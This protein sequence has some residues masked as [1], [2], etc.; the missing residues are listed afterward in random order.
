MSFFI[1]ENWVAEKKAVIHRG[2]CSF[3]NNGRGI[4][5]NIRGKKMA[6]GMVLLMVTKMQESLLKVLGIEKLEIVSS[7]FKEMIEK[8]LMGTFKGFVGFKGCGRKEGYDDMK[9]DNAKEIYPSPT[10]DKKCVE[11]GD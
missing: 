7:A 8:T 2:E 11:G 1:Y 6:C 4:H 9:R 10:L 3:C 5:Q